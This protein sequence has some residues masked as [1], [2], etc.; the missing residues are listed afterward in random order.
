MARK[1]KGIADQAELL[2][3]LSDMVA[4]ESVNTLF[5]KGG[6]DEKNIVNYICNYYDRNGNGITG[7]SGR[8]RKNHEDTWQRLQIT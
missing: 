7:E 1:I 5:G 6:S 3:L 2:Q 8:K 4:I